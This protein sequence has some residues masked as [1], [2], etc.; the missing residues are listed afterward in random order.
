MDTEDALL[1]ARARCLHDLTATGQDD[2]DTV[3]LLDETVSDRRWWVETWPEGATFVPGLVAQDLQ[4]ALRDTGTRWPGCPLAGDDHVL[5][6]EPDIGGPEP[7]W[8]CEDC[9]QPV[10]PLGRLTPD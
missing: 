1:A 8:V 2:P 5:R 4:D 10:A 3:S 9:E 7:T 6:I